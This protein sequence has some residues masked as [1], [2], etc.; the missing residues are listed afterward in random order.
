MYYHE[1]RLHLVHVLIKVRGAVLLQHKVT[2][3]WGALSSYV[4]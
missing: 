3:Q 1:P 2:V 4:P